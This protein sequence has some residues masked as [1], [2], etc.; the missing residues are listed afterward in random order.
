M[1]K[2]LAYPGWSHGV[3]GI[4]EEAGHTGAHIRVANPPVEP[5]RG[6]IKNYWKQALGCRFGVE[7][8]R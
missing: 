7:F 5:R 2:R 8:P 6:E 1:R 3:C 4:R